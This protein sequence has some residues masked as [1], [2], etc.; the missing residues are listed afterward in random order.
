[1]DDPSHDLHA[2]IQS[3]EEHQ[4]FLERQIEHISSEIH[5]LGSLVHS[6]KSQLELER[7]RLATLSDSLQP[8]P[9]SDQITPPPPIA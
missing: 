9:P 3:L 1:M 5:A 8:P 4:L 6:L 2:R 7:Q